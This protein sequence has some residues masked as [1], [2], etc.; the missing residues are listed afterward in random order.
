[1]SHGTSVY[2]TTEQKT[3][4]IG[5]CEKVRKYRLYCDTHYM[6]WLRHGDPLAVFPLGRPARPGIPNLQ[7]VRESFGLSRTEFGRLV[8]LNRH[9]VRTLERGYGAKE[10]VVHRVH[11]AVSELFRERRER[12]EKAGVA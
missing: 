12:L 11:E 9:Q 1:M 7:A 8:G 5:G 3:C 6:R 4:S 2:S 10:D